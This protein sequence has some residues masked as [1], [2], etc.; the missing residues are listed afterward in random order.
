MLWAREDEEGRGEEK[1]RGVQGKELVAR[2]VDWRERGERGPCVLL[3]LSPSTSAL[4]ALRR[5]LP[6]LLSPFLESLFLSLQQQQ[7]RE[8]EEEEEE[9]EEKSADIPR[10][11]DEKKQAFANCRAFLSWPKNSM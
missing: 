2:T 4:M 9:E 7:Q 3:S 1:R 8:E 6:L 10:T 11:D 5:L